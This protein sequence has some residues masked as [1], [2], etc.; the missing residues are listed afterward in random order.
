MQQSHQ[1]KPAKLT[2]KADKQLDLDA[3]ELHQ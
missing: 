1:E 2:I 3:L